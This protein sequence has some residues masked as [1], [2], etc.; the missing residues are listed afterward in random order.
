MSTDQTE[1]PLE[2][3]I[4]PKLCDFTETVSFGVDLGAGD[5]CTVLGPWP[6]LRRRLYG[7]ECSVDLTDERCSGT[8]T[9][10]VPPVKP[11]P[12][13]LHPL[14]R[15]SSHPSAFGQSMWKPWEGGKVELP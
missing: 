4:C 6:L 2:M 10:T 11:Q 14:Q 12:A 7:R 15:M 13:P 5:D 1:E 9:L 3:V 8:V